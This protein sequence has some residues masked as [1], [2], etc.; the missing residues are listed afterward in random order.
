MYKFRGSQSVL[1]QVLIRLIAQLYNFN[2]L[3]FTF[4]SNQDA[5]KS[6]AIGYQILRSGY[7]VVRHLRATKTSHYRPRFEKT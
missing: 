4:K 5:G 1:K 6:H 7:G 3:Q 2:L